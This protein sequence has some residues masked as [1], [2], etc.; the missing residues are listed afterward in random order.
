[1]N[2][3]PRP[4]ARQAR[5]QRAHGI[6]IEDN[7]WQLYVSGKRQVAIANELNISESRVSRY[8]SRRLQRIEENAPHSAEKLKVM[9][10]IMNARLESIYEEA[11]RL[12]DSYK[13]IM[14]RLKTLE[15]MARLNGL[16]LER[17][18]HTAV[19]PPAPYSSPPEIAKAVQQWMLKR[20]GY[21][22]FHLPP[23]P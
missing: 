11:G 18:C 5:R 9:R 23:Q 7:V 17:S 21:A 19:P 22:D 2:R 8:V 12:E 4:L 15:Q 1:M 16:N 20:Y 13:G 14:I 6:E 3:Q 10:H